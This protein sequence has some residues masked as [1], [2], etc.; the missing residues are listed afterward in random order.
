MVCPY[1][2]S[3]LLPRCIFKHPNGKPADVNTTVTNNGDNMAS[4][5]ELG[6]R[7]GRL[8][9][10]DK[11]NPAVSSIQL[12][13]A[14][15]AKS[16]P[17]SPSS[18][19]SLKR[20]SADTRYISPPPL[21]R[22]TDADS[23]VTVKPPSSQVSFAPAALTSRI[24]VKAPAKT[25]VKA[26]PQAA[27]KSPIRAPVKVP[28]KEEGLNPR[29]LRGTAP[30]SHD[31]R[32]RLLRALHEQLVRL[33]TEVAND[34]SDAEESLVLSAQDLIKKALD[35]EEDAAAVP[36]IYPNMVKNKILVYKRM[37]VKQWVDERTK[38]VVAIK[39]KEAGLPPPKPVEPPAPIESSLTTEQELALLPRIYTP[40][41]HLTA[42]GY[43]NSIPTEKDIA[44]AK[45]GIAAA[46][47]WEL[48]DRCRTR[49]QVFPGRREEDGALASNGKCTY[50]FGKPYFPDRDPKDPKARREK[51]YRCCG[52]GLGE[53]SGCT[54]SEYHVF[55]IS[56]VKRLAAVLNFE[57]TPENPSKKG[58]RPVCIDG[59]MGYTVYGL[60]LIRLTATSWPDGASLFDVLV[61]PVGL[62]LD[63]NSRYSGVWPKDFASALPYIPSSNEL[64]TPPPP[65][66]L[67]PPPLPHHHL[68]QTQ[69]QNHPN[70]ASSLPQLMLA[71]SSS[72]T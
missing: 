20:G 64:G 18:D 5:L 46:K 4:Q 28:V 58:T 43:V 54:K 67:P 30:A 63:L 13:A 1:S 36:S 8:N 55:K 34:A 70:S 66:E 22:K 29:A 24:A 48:C 59:E 57:I 62:V 41:G 33:N 56:E 42:H 71:R 37:S 47:G 11:P 21:R 12:E 40:V 16:S 49:F 9:D 65:D 17:Q 7:Y 51:K 69:S 14:T 53:S 19:K 25:S 52:E 61:K 27:T 6:G 35:I 3:C 32:F 72:R 38:E 50:H 2:E 44:S 68:T 39:A 10:Q 26:S 45:A 60:E 23:H 15:P 31:M